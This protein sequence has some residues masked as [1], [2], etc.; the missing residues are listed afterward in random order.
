ML[1][2]LLLHLGIREHADLAATI[3]SI[4]IILEHVL[5]SNEMLV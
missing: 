5:Q 1:Y 2:A 3:N 4:M